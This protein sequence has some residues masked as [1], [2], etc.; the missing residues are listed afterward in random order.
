MSQLPKDTASNAPGGDEEPHSGSPARVGRDL[1]NG[2]G[3]LTLREALN[4]YD[5]LRVHECE[6]PAVPWQ[7]ARHV[8]VLNVEERERALHEK[9]C[10]IYNAFSDAEQRMIQHF[11]LTAVHRG[12][13]LS[14]RF[15]INIVASRERQAA[16]QSEY[17]DLTE[18]LDD[19]VEA[20]A[21]HAT[22]AAPERAHLLAAAFLWSMAWWVHAR[23]DVAALR[24]VQ[25]SRAEAVAALGR[26]AT[27]FDAVGSKVY[28]EAADAEIEYQG[29]LSELADEAARLNQ[30]LD[31]S[32]SPPA[33]KHLTPRP[34]SPREDSPLNR[35]PD[36]PAHL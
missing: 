7:F 30:D 14:E 17:D 34:T 16:T 19:I 20:V 1:C 6:Q 28:Q 36:E 18:E 27:P 29:Y 35:R 3:Q 15:A 33:G 23:K 2:L 31:I 21:K 12:S 24:D 25:G 26:S 11:F 5:A 22:R 9:M 4:E 8:C 10:R 32:V 13:V